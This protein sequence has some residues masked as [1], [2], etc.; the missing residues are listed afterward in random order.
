MLERLRLIPFL[1]A[2]LLALT[3]PATASAGYEDIYKECQDGTLK[4]TYSAKELQQAAQNL[5]G[6]NADYTYCSDAIHR[7][8]TNLGK[9]NGGSNG[10]GSGSGAGAGAGN[11]GGGAGGATGAGTPTG[12]L[13]TDGATGGQAAAS[14][15]VVDAAADASTEE[16]QQSVTTAMQAATAAQAQDEA[17]A[18][19]RV[20]ASALDLGASGG[21]LPTPLLVA[22]IVCG[23]AACLA[24]AAA[25][26]QAV[27]R[28]RAR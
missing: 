9:K 5:N 26:V 12:D 24:G 7:A 16:D 10:S 1:I 11:P 6:Y 23:A 13:P 3:I 22:L 19:V 28:H 4:N 15:D 21:T 18:G 8:Q 25:V 2:A 20:P 17:L 14:T 27:R